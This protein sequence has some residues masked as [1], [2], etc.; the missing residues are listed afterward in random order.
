M[1]GRDG[2]QVEEEELAWGI[3]EEGGSGQTKGG[4]WL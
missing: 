3:R 2:W 1:V 4:W